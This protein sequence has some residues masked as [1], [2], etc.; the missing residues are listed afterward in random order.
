MRSESKAEREE[1][2]LRPHQPIARRCSDPS[3]PSSRT[4]HLWFKPR[5]PPR[6]TSHSAVK[7][8][9]YQHGMQV[10]CLINDD[11]TPRYVYYM[12]Q[13]EGTEH[14]WPRIVIAA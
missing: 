7:G 13:S 4:D 14:P 2:V 11:I 1:A 5:L 3:I 10:H 6:S 8:N 12:P 9:Q